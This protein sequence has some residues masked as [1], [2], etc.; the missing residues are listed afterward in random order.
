MRPSWW[1]CWSVA[2]VLLLTLTVAPRA[3]GQSGRTAPNAASNPG[4]AGAAAEK[5]MIAGVARSAA[6]E[7]VRYAPVRL[8]NARTGKVA[9]RT[10]TDARGDFAFELT[11]AGIYVA[12]LLDRF[13]QVIAAG[14]MVVIEEGQSVDT[15]ITLPMRVRRDAWFSNAA[16]AV[17]AA[18]TSA[19]VLAVAATG[20]TASAVR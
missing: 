7:P 16:G 2:A 3:D 11:Q 8:R 13:G 15:V 20:P 5:T 6:E 18:A 14:D 19:G 1:T 4:A 9:G 10:T 12:E 17:I